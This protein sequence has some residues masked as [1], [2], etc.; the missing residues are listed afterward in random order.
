MKI[1]SKCCQFDQMIKCY[2]IFGFD[3][4]S[5]SSHQSKCWTRWLELG[6]FWATLCHPPR[7]DSGW[8]R[9]KSMWR[10]DLLMHTMV[11]L[12]KT[13][14]CLS[15]GKTFTGIGPTPSIAKNIAAEAAVHHIAT[16]MSRWKNLRLQ[17]KFSILQLLIMRITTPYCNYHEQWPN[18]GRGSDWPTVWGQVGR[19]FE[20]QK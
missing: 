19:F 9:L 11:S 18:W 3:Q 7:M 20:L 4:P 8:P 14:I 1:D 16:I 15:Q 10:L 5:N 12:K 6:M 2:L 17:I 13:W